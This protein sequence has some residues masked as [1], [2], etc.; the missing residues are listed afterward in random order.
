M[1][2]NSETMCPHLPLFRECRTDVLCA[3]R[4]LIMINSH[5]DVLARGTGMPGG[6][7]SAGHV[8]LRNALA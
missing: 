6:T 2:A 5:D 1:S 7:T 3:A 8:G 4:L